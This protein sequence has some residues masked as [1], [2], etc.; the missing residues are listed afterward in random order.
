MVKKS[1]TVK[2]ISPHKFVVSY[3]EHLKKQGKIIL[4]KWVDIVKTA[5]AKEL[6]PSNPDWFYVH[7][8]AVARAVYLRPGVGVQGLRKRYG[9][10]K[11]GGYAP[12]H[13]DVASRAVQRK[14]LQELERIGVLGSEDKAKNPHS[15]R[16]V[17]P[18]GQ[19]DM[20]LI[21][22]SIQLRKI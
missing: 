7:C 20:D 16:F 9:C 21:A 12:Y 10:V 15:G 5:T 4:P 14:C 19:R 3:A 1:A 17:T 8:A 18:E 22:Q 2:D 13:H 6:P 11:N